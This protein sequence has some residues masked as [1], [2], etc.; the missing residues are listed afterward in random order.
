MSEGNSLSAGQA[1]AFAQ[2]TT[3]T[4]AVA[5]QFEQT[6]SK[7][8][9]D[10]I[11]IRHELG[12]QLDQIISEEANYGSAAV[13]QLAA[14]LALSPDFLYK[15]HTYAQLYGREQ[16]VQWAERRMSNGGMIT[17]N[18]LTTIMAVKSEPQRQTL[19]ERIFDESLSVRDLRAVLRRAENSAQGRS[20]DG[21]KPT[22][23]LRGLNR[24]IAQ[25]RKML[26]SL[27]LHDEAIF[28]AIDIG[29]VES[30]TLDPAVRSKLQETQ[31]ILADLT[32]GLGALSARAAQILDRT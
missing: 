7:E 23:P 25:A 21:A 13:E 29:R 12:R 28:A 32:D 9:R 4:Q 24:L 26:K 11:L 16:I 5:R 18:H 15:L 3:A 31:A 2:M 14:Y 17:F 27:P 1:E 19:V 20:E 6:L 10:T 30:P 22:T 8:R